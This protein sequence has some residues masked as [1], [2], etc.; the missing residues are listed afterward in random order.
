MPYCH[1]HPSPDTCSICYRY[2]SDLEFAA[3]IDQVP[4]PPQP[5]LGRKKGVVDKP[6]M[7][8][9]EISQARGRCQEKKKQGLPC[10]EFQENKEE[11]QVSVQPL[12]WS[13]GVTTV[14]SRFQD[15]L[16]QTLES[17]KQGGFDKPRL[18]IDGTDF[19][20]EP[21]YGLEVTSRQPSLRAYGNWLLALLE[22]YIR[23]PLADRYAIF[24]DDMICCK[25]LRGYL[26]KVNYQPNTYWNLLTFPQNQA[27]IDAKERGIYEGGKQTGLPLSPQ[28]RIGWHEGKTLVST[29]PSK[30]QQGL[31]AVALV[32]NRDAAMTLLASKHM[33]TRIQDPQRGHKLI[34]GGVVTAMNQA[35]YKEMIHNPSLVQHMGIKSTVGNSPHPIA[36]SFRGAD[37]DCLQLLQEAKK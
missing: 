4:P 9:S 32:F 30:W 8:F 21:S 1:R 6:R 13:Y 33:I 15:L 31:G 7:S 11:S 24:Q 27:L 12:I 17:L 36:P 14:P 22:L 10:N 2:V 3:V 26:D 16:P 28:E 18:F 25:N 29:D 34:D 37:Y 20:N 35:G 23:E 19:P 5:F